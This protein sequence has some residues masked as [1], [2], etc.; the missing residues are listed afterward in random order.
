MDLSTIIRKTRLAIPAMLRY[1]L[2]HSDSLSAMKKTYSRELRENWEEVT[3]KTEIRIYKHGSIYEISRK[4]YTDGRFERE[5]TWLASYAWS[6][7]GHLVA[8]GRETCFFFDPL[9][10]M[11]YLEDWDGKNYQLEIYYESS[12]DL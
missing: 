7:S 12:T 11:L 9:S 1:W 3:Q 8:L 10:K 2:S 5:E 6:L 4:F